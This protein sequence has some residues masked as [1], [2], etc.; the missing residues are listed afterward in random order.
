MREFSRSTWAR[1]PR[2]LYLDLN[3]PSPASFRAFCRFAAVLS[4]TCKALHA[5]VASSKW[6]PFSPLPVIAP[7]GTVSE[8]LSGRFSVTCRPGGGGEGIQRALDACEEGGSILCLEGTYEVTELI[9]LDKRVHVFG[10]GAALLRGSPP[11]E[12]FVRSTAEGATLDRLAI[13]SAAAQHSFAVGVQRGR[14]RL[15]GCHVTAGARGACVGGVLS[16]SAMDVIGGTLQGGGCGAFA[17]YGARVSLSHVEIVGCT[18]FGYNV[19]GPGTNT[20]C[21]RCRFRDCVWGV[22]IARDVDPAWAIGEGNTFEGCQS[23]VVDERLLPDHMF[24]PA[25][26]GAGAAG[27]GGAEGDAALPPGPLAAPALPLAAAVVG[28]GIEAGIIAGEDAAPPGAAVEL[29]PADHVHPLGMVQDQEALAAPD[30]DPPPAGPQQ[31]AVPLLFAPAAAAA[32]ADVGVELEQLD[33][34]EI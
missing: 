8:P 5:A 24:Q 33:L 16:L 26:A 23:D 29:E 34:V 14:L 1:G 4:T 30:P 6:P 19:Q 9:R 11:S 28:A 27:A 21:A 22:R 15:Q 31:L 17:L 32:A 3:A 20:A 25:A 13:A 10:R 12:F 2:D 18:G 7:D